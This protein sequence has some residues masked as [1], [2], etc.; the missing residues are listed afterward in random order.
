ME[1]KIPLDFGRQGIST[2]DDPEKQIEW[3]L[4]LPVSLENGAVARVW[5]TPDLA[6][7]LPH[8]ASFQVG[9]NPLQQE[10]TLDGRESSVTARVQARA[11]DLIALGDGELVFTGRMQIDAGEAEF[12]LADAVRLENGQYELPLHLTAS[13][14]TP[15]PWGL[16]GLGALGAALAVLLAALIFAMR[17]VLP[18][19][20][21]L[22]A[23]GVP[24]DIGAVKRATIGGPAD[25]VPL[26][27]SQSVGSIAGRWGFGGGARFTAARDVVVGGQRIGEGEKVS[28]SDGDTIVADHQT[29]AYHDS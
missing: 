9:E 13:V 20:T 7:A 14:S 22:E 2:T 18:R 10:V 3:I 24:Y 26:G 1:S 11:G 29:F 6:P 4:P 19:D 17:P 5:F 8:S 21:R 28:L 15:P 27:L 12:P 16:I 23:G 25:D